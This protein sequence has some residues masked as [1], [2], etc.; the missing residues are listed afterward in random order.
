MENVGYDPDM[1]HVNVHTEK[2]NHV[3]K[4][5]KGA[6][7]KL[8][9]PYDAFHVYAVEWTPEA[10]DFSI[11]G[12]KAFHFKNEGT[13]PAAWPY[14]RP[15]FLILNVAIG[16]DW[17]GQKGIDAAI[18]PQRMEVDYVRVYRKA[19]PGKSR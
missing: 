11:D 2:Y 8:A 13:G 19:S 9:R 16:G 14:D 6:S 15:H 17:G 10:M 3:R 18:F 7:V 4:T 1:I 5:N 12:K